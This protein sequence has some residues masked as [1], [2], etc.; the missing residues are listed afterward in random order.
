MDRVTAPE[1]V[2]VAEGRWLAAD[3]STAAH[4]EGAQ[5]LAAEVEGLR[6]DCEAMLAAR[7][8]GEGFPISSGLGGRTGQTGESD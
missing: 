8:L 1:L 7:P 2:E 6:E 5:Q 3:C 4:L